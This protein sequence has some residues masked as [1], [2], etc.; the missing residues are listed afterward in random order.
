MKKLWHLS[1]K[2]VGV[3]VGGGFLVRSWRAPI[4]RCEEEWPSWQDRQLAALQTPPHGQ[5]F[6]DSFRDVDRES[7]DISPP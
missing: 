4:Q 5:L 6:I 1:D 2:A 3:C 7:A